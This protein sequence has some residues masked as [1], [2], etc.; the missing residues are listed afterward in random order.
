VERINEAS[1]AEKGTLPP[2]KAACVQKLQ[3][4]TAHSHPDS[5][6][7]ILP[8]LDQP[9]P[10]SSVMANNPSAQYKQKRL[11]KEPQLTYIGNV[12]LLCV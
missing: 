11:P 10:G 2:R 1:Q 8:T 12:M 3:T 9:D 5:Q 4:P 6:W 7:R